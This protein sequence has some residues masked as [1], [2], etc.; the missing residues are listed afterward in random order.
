LVRDAMDAAAAH[1]ERRC[2]G[3]RSR[4]VLMP[5][6]WHQVGDDA[7]HHAGDGGKKA[8]SPGRARRKP[9]KPLRREGRMIPPTPVVLPVCLLPLHT[10]RGCE[11]STRPSLRPL[12]LMGGRN[13]LT[14]LG[15]IAPRGCGCLSCSG[16]IAMPELNGCLTIESEESERRSSALFTAERGWGGATPSAEA[17]RAK[18]EAIPIHRGCGDDRFREGLNPSC[19][20]C[21]GRF[22]A[23]EHGCDAR[24]QP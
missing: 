2:G 17:Q 5:R 13:F 6:R 14:K 22:P 1:D 9:L 3:R 21:R 8:R 23:R 20:A 16:V 4:V 12:V 19:T 15:R 7:S 11:L 10:G 18:A 24:S